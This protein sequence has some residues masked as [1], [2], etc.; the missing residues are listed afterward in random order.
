MISPGD[1][2]ATDGAP[3]LI[4]AVCQLWPDDRQRCTVHRVRNDSRS[5]ETRAGPRRL[6]YWGTLDEA[7][8]GA[9]GRRRVGG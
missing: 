4:S 5:S 1:W 6:A 2:D 3:G 7:T 9:D 8:D